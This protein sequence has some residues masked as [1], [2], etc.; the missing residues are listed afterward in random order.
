MN[1]T[2]RAL[3]VAL[4]LTFPLVAAACG[5]GS[6]EAT[7]TDKTGSTTP[8]PAK[9]ATT[10]PPHTTFTA[11]VKNTVPKV[12]IY[13]APGDATPS[14]V[15][16]NPWQVDPDYPDALVPQVF[17]VKQQRTDGW[18]QVLLP[19]RPNG[20][21][22]WVKASDVT[23]TPNPYHI[24][25]SLG[26]HTITVSRGDQQIYTGKVAVGAPDTPTPTGEYYLRVLVKAIDPTTVY[27][28]YAYGLSSHSDAL[29]TFAGGDAEI[30]I[31]GNNDASVLGSDITH[32]CMRM[33]ND[34]ITMLSKQLPLGTPVEITA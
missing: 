19:V 3:F 32:G 16:D 22:G 21:K 12:S 11:T 34:A 28:P 8:H 23:V 5:G 14:R 9:S 29:E 27:G 2:R 20:S 13:G 17:L 4:A 10:L 7:V 6:G 18:V 31:H 33:D 25:V 26:Q 1:R 24:E 30:G 15:L